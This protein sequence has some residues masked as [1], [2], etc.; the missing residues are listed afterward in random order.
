MKE[1]V[2]AAIGLKSFYSSVECMEWGLEDDA[3]ARERNG[4][5]GGHRA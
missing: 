5:I 3:T 1:K 2:Y 4:T